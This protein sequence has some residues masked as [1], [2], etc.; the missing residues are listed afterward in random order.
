GVSRPPARPGP[1]PLAA[2][3]GLDPDI[4]FLNHGSFGSCP[5]LVLG[6]QRHHRNLMEREPVTFF[7]KSAFELMDRSRAAVAGLIGGRAEDFVFVSN[8]TVA[9]NTIFE[10]AATGLGLAEDRPLGPGD[11]ILANSLEYPACMANARRLAE[12]TGASLRVVDIPRLDGAMTPGRF[13]ELL[14][15]GVTERTRLCLLSHVISPT[16][17]VLPAAEIIR[18]LESRGVATILDGAHGPGCIPVEI[19]ATKPAFYTANAHKWLCA[20][21]G[22][23]ILYVRPDLQERFRPQ[24]LSVYDEA[25][26]GVLDRSRYNRDFDYVGTDDVSAKL[27]IADAIELVPEVAG[28]SWPAMIERNNALAL[29]AA[30]LLRDRLGTNPCQTNDMIGPMAMIELPTMPEAHRERLEARPK[31]FL[32]ALQDALFENH[33]IQVPVY[34]IGGGRR[35]ARISAQVYNTIEQ[36]EYLASALLEELDRE[37]R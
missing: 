29:E 20:P 1:S 10:N 16:G 8:A 6:A 11:E 3:F 31:V 13:T 9:V 24:T 32:D 7:M 5:A 35:Y 26:A 33:G 19:E 14:I 18:A 30:D 23:A 12:R 4:V 28:R 34:S 27:T 22:A 25:P 36:Y 2:E 15:D 37:V 21:K 17:W